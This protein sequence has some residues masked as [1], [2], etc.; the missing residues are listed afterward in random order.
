MG[1]VTTRGGAL[2]IVDV[3]SIAPNVADVRDLSWDSATSV[4]VLGKAAG[5]TAPVRVTVDG[6]SVVLV[7]RVGLEQSRPVSLTA[8]PNQPLVVAALFGGTP[9]LY[10]ESTLTYVRETVGAEPFYPG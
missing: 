6:S 4:I 2:R 7:N 10:R 5:V 3:R 8:A 1:R 9:V